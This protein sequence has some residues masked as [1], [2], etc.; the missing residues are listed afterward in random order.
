MVELVGT[1]LFYVAYMH[2]MQLQQE[3]SNKKNQKKC[4]IICEWLL[5]DGLF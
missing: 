3:E 5:V 4:K 2:V 1:I